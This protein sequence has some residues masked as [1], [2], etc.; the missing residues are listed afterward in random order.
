VLPGGGEDA[1]GAEVEVEGSV[2]GSVEE[3]ADIVAESV[4]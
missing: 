1:G 3:G 2:E 4:V